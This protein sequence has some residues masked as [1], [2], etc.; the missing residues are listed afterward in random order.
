ML[1]CSITNFHIANILEIFDG[2]IVDLNNIE[3]TNST[4]YASPVIKISLREG[5]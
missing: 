3:I 1:N 4:Y 2:Y 5:N